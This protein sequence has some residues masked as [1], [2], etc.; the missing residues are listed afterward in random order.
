MI[1]ISAFWDTDRWYSH[2]CRSRSG[3]ARCDQPAVRNWSDIA[4]LEFADS[5]D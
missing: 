1:R 2:F 5:T 3:F 4:S